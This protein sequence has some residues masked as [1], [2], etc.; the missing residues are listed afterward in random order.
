MTSGLSSNIRLR[1]FSDIREA[2]SSP[3]RPPY[4]STLPL[5]TYMRSYPVHLPRVSIEVANSYVSV[6]KY[7][8]NLTP[9]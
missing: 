6:L 3:A 5:N 2:G 1:V 8:L 7:G 4:L 9:V